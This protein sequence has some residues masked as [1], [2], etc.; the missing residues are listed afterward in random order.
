MT[1]PLPDLPQALH[2]P[3]E[4]GGVR[5]DRVLGELWPAL[6]RTR[7]RA[8]LEAGGVRVDGAPAPRA[9]SPVSA[10]A[11]I[12]LDLGLT[13]QRT[14]ASDPG[15]VLRVIHED[16]HVAVVDKP[17]GLL[18]HPGPTVRGGTL[19]EQAVARWGPLPSLQ[20]EDRPG[21]VHRLDAGT[22][23][24]LVLALREEAMRELLRQFRE[25]EVEKTYLA[26]VHGEP[27]FDTGWLEGAIARS[28]GAPGRMEVVPD[29]AGREA[30]TWYE[31][32]E[33]LGAASLLACS[34]RTGRTHQIRVHLAHLGH[35]LVGDPAY[36]LRQTPALRLDPATPIPARQAL[37]AAELAFT[38]PASG[39]RL[40]F[41]SPLPADLEALLAHLRG[42]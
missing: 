8:A 4:L 15:L 26:V 10:G 20:G 23:G 11:R 28:S 9:S 5:L 32:R 42:A 29:G 35:P 21:I 17:A 39:E 2:V 18:V 30:V 19:S 16:E 27:R 41:E 25:R 14:R 37:H 38:H 24:I 31:V 13:A 6:S 36:R 33:R 3:P 34:P 40:R 7:L 12:D 1:L 22:S